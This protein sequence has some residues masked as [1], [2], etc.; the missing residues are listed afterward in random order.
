M[1]IYKAQFFRFKDRVMTEA[2]RKYPYKFTDFGRVYFD[3]AHKQQVYAEWQIATEP[4]EVE[5]KNGVFLISELNA[6]S[7]KHYLSG[8]RVRLTDNSGYQTKHS[9]YYLLSE[10]AEQWYEKTKVALAK[11]A[12]ARTDNYPCWL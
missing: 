10:E 1:K 3:E 12:D 4:E 11:A 9:D 7:D 5:V 6:H 2:E 8:R